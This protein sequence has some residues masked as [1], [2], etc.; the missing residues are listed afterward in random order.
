MKNYN[1]MIDR[2]NA[3]DQP[4]NQPIRNN[5]K[6]YQNIQWKHPCYWYVSCGYK[7][8][9]G[10]KNHTRKIHKDLNHTKS[11][12]KI[13]NTKISQYSHYTYWLQKE[14][15]Q[16]RLRVL[17]HFGLEVSRH[18][19]IENHKRKSSNIH[20]YFLIYTNFSLISFYVK[21]TQNLNFTYYLNYFPLD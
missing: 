16:F 10:W 7:D 18:F 17:T 3:F 13:F 19:G 15:T 9:L 6:T 4:I 8:I 14:L 21:L 20:K 5:I 12:C 2:W 1:A 11:L